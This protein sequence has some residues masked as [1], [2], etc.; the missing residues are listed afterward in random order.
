MRVIYMAHHLGAPTREG[1]LENLARAK[2]WY[3]WIM[4]TFDVAIVAD[5]IISCEL[6]DDAVP[7]ARA[8]G[9]SMNSALVARCDEVW[10]VGGRI[11]SGM[12]FEKECGDELEMRIMDLTFLGVEPPDGVVPEVLR[13][14]GPLREQQK[15]AA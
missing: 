1:M 7:A 2:R 3:V 10:L 15:L 11:S 14:I 12:E 5:W 9:L 8:L 4:K 13:L 6:F